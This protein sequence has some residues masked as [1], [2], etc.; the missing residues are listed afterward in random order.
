MCFLIEI[1]WDKIK[2]G[3]FLFRQKISEISQSK[4]SERNGYVSR[5]CKNFSEYWKNLGS[6]PIRENSGNSSNNIQVIGAYN[7]ENEL[8]G[9]PFFNRNFIKQKNV[10]PAQEPAFGS[11]SKRDGVIAVRWV[12]AKQLLGADHSIVKYI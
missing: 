4:Q 2:Y 5:P 6:E 7:S 10:V 11:Q 8:F 3:G 1:Q 9:C 12:S